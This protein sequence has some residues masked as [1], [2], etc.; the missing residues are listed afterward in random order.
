[1]TVVRA[2]PS[3]S[4]GRASVAISATAIDPATVGGPSPVVAAEWFEGADPGA[5]QGY[6]LAAADG[7]FGDSSENIVGS[8][9]TA[10]MPFGEHLLWLRARDGAGNW[11]TT[12]PLVVSI[13]PA[14]G[15]FADGFEAGTTGAWTSTSGAG[16]VTVST[17]AAAAGRFG[18]AVTIA[19]K[20]AGYV[21]DAS[22]AAETAY[23]ARFSMAPNGVTMPS[24]AIMDIFVGRDAR[25]TSVFTLQHRR[26]AAGT[27]QVRASVARKSG[28]S[29]TG[30][31]SLI[32]SMT[33][34]ELAWASARGSTVSLLV[35]GVTAATL[36]GLDT[37][38]YRL[39][40]VRLGPSGGLA[41]GTSGTI[42][43][44]RFVSD[45]T[46]LLGP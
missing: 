35:N 13:T 30:W 26:T 22:P 16:R 25:G 5:G 38:A 1:M 4:Q 32:G 34:I 46:T 10:G 12:S 41:S 43:F 42:Y 44:D 9:D 33:T 6:P 11:G 24:G 37:S 21:T 45:R 36:T 2:T 31:I 17:A 7:A 8:V 3:P 40:E 23:R 28:T 27:P 29:T 19:G 14:D 18:L 20:S 39:E 15:I